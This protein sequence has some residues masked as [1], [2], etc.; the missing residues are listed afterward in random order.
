MKKIVSVSGGEFG[1]FASIELVGDA[2]VCDRVVYPISVVGEVVIEDWTPSVPAAELDLIKRTLSNR[3]DAKVAEVYSRWLRFDA[4]YVARE[5][6]ARAFLVDETPSVWVSG[7]AGPA[8]MT[9]REAAELI[10]AQADSLRNALQSLGALRMEKYRI[11]AA[12]NID[13][14]N[15]EY[16]RIT[17]LIND[18][19]EAL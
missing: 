8:G 11:L 19:A 16:V 3:V 6:A 14:A 2:Y 10:V 17:A 4:E 13:L 9:E 12:S 18:I 7:F 1:P 5:A 15:D